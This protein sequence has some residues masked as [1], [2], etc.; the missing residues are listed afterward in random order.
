MANKDMDEGQR[1]SAE[2]WAWYNKKFG[3]QAAP[4][5]MQGLESGPPIVASWAPDQYQTGSPLPPNSTEELRQVQP[6][7]A[8]NQGPIP[9]QVASGHWPQQ[10]PQGHEA[11]YPTPEQAA[12]YQYWNN[13]Q[14]WSDPQY[15]SYNATPTQIVD[16]PEVASIP[17]PP[18]DEP[19]ESDQQSVTEEM[20]REVAEMYHQNED[21]AN[22]AQGGK[23]TVA[24]LLE[25]LRYAKKVQLIY[26]L[27]SR[28]QP[29][30]SAPFQSSHAISKP[31]EGR[32][33]LVIPV[34]DDMK[35]YFQRAWDGATMQAGYEW[36]EHMR[37]PTA[38]K[39]IGAISQPHRLPGYKHYAVEHVKL[40]DQ[41]TE[42]PWA[43]VKRDVDLN[44]NLSFVKDQKDKPWDSRV[45]EFMNMN[46]R[47]LMMINQSMFVGQAYA[48][49]LIDLAPD[50]EDIVATT[51]Y[52]AFSDLLDINAQTVDHMASVATNQQLNMMLGKRDEALI[53]TSLTDEQKL[54]LR[55][56]T[57]KHSATG[58]HELFSGKLNKFTEYRGDRAE[59][60]LVIN[61]GEI[62]K[63]QGKRN[64]PQT[65]TQPPAKKFQPG[66][67]PRR[68]GFGSGNAPAYQSS[69][70]SFRDSDSR[71]GDQS[72][73]GFKGK[74]SMRSQDFKG[75][76]SRQD[77][78]GGRG[79]RGGQRRR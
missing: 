40:P 71:R 58:G 77:S 19:Q 25:E 59:R 24:D 53:R 16:K 10:G 57:P 6:N 9:G 1:I 45:D 65:F 43:S 22:A 51:N 4:P 64:T 47:L 50:P 37:P 11:Y 56:A 75:Q 60:S 33:I 49:L 3:N 78:R 63:N 21:T 23:E 34:M 2:Y 28:V 66:N 42:W 62:N 32:P 31:K 12:Y 72:S 46:G 5:A 69:G 17:L 67:N 79:Q 61:M 54:L 73:G 13:H 70:Q 8:Y 15:Y 7:A 55:Y 36:D 20:R 39:K 48:K 27:G 29:R 68:G 44:T 35:D 18:A 38:G 26:K 14:Y 52:K 30:D 74:G 41:K 76:G